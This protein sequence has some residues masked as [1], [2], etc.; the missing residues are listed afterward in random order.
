MFKTLYEIESVQRWLRRRAEL[1]KAEYLTRM[2]KFLV[3]SGP[4]I[5]VHDPDGF[6]AWAK[7]QPSGV[8]VQDLIDKYTE[9]MKPSTAHV[10]VAVLRGFLNRNGYRELPKIDWESTM[11]FA[12]G[13]TRQQ[14]QELLGYLDRPLQKLY[15][16]SMKDSG[17]RAN[18][19]LY[20]RYKHIKPDLEAGKDFVNIRFE[21]ERYKRRKAPGL[22]FLGPNSVSLLREL[23]KSGEVKRD[24]DARI[25]PYP[26]RTI[27]YELSLAKKRASLPKE[28]QPNHGL[29]KFFHYGLQAAR[30]A[31]L[32][33]KQFEG[34]SNGTRD[35]K[36]VV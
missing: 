21:D 30:I 18:D 6:L 16:L 12:E 35:R 11:S 8:H 34:H 22:T 25:F 14:I 29:R 7:K 2:D 5:K 15:V 17:L 23:L 31:D 28:V 24:P 4:A 19:L 36:S 20:L 27:T 10:H 32:K 33:A 3:W 13:Y 9:G 1:T 26:Y